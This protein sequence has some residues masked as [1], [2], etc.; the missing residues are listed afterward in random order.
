MDNH[1]Q[2]HPQAR[3]EN[4]RRKAEL[5]KHNSLPGLHLAAKEQSSFHCKRCGFINTLLP[6]CLWCSWSPNEAGP[7][8]ET[9]PSK[10]PTRR[11]SSPALLRMTVEARPNPRSKRGSTIKQAY[12]HSTHNSTIMPSYPPSVA[13]AAN[14]LLQEDSIPRN[15]QQTA[16]RS[17][18]S[19]S[20]MGRSPERR[21]TAR[22]EC[23]SET[24]FTSDNG[25]PESKNTPS[26]PSLHS[27][28][29]PL[30]E[31]SM[32]NN[33]DHVYLARRVMANN[34]PDVDIPHWS[35]VTTAT[36]ANVPHKAALSSKLYHPT[37]PPALSNSALA[38]GQAQTPQEEAADITTDLSEDHSPSDNAL[39]ETSLSNKSSGDRL[40][41]PAVNFSGESHIPHC[42]TPSC[43]LSVERPFSDSMAV[44]NKKS[45][46][47]LK[48]T[49][50]G[51]IVDF[52]D[53]KK[54]EPHHYDDNDRHFIYEESNVY[55]PSNSTDSKPSSP[56][57]SI[58]PRP[59]QA[60]G[61]LRTLRRKKHLRINVV[62]PYA[63]DT[64]ASEP[65]AIS[66]T[67][68]AEPVSDPQSSKTVSHVA[69]LPPRDI[70]NKSVSTISVKNN[71]LA[72]LVLSPMSTIE[73]PLNSATPS[74]PDD[75]L[76]TS[77]SPIAS[78][79]V[80]LGHPSRPYY[81]A[82]RKHGVSPPSSRPS[83]VIGSRPVSPARPKSYNPPSS[84]NN[85]NTALTN[86]TNTTSAAR[87]MSMSAAFAPGTSTG[88]SAFSVQDDDGISDDDI[89]VSPPALAPARLSLSLSPGRVKRSSYGNETSKSD[90][91]R[92]GRASMSAAPSV[93]THGIGF[94][95][96]GE[97]EL[98][99]ALAAS[100]G[101]T[102]SGFRY[103]YQATTR[104]SGETER[105]PV[106][107][108]SPASPMSAG[109]GSPP[110]AWGNYEG[111]P[112][113]SRNSFVKRV[114]KLRKG[115]KEM[116]SNAPA[117]PC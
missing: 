62:Q 2:R 59:Q 80:K 12:A 104:P 78:S 22:L 57:R 77:N 28:H 15:V 10:S 117:S 23:D 108:V 63:D 94:S 45:M 31:S 5:H 41:K 52:D 51:F 37:H 95:M 44:A 66:L 68:H 35:N 13:L 114:K 58:A 115:L 92:S 18:L 55:T 25:I 79:P 20:K 46:R 43:P 76:M 73:E 36:S 100:G 116:L 24:A 83:S 113:G 111:L 30:Y 40:S 64:E 38:F 11:V 101:A 109:A 89:P 72:P 47:T 82:I 61:P 49:H 39:C 19:L 102:E 1:H 86:L 88:L 91:R 48:A 14:I 87:H 74:T 29:E 96:S 33:S 6:L 53:E 67:L 4:R 84:F 7:G 32:C 16:L 90:K 69:S 103:N 9:Q 99:M 107:P 21:S 17:S 105:S 56:T 26:V 85:M 27:L 50:R 70:S 60:G 42:N 81:T 71:K 98:R 54:A 65:I 34:D 112:A 97:T 3:K 75:T 8:R 106:S 93:P 110:S